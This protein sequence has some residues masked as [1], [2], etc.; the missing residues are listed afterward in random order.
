[1]TVR[2]DPLV[3]LYMVRV[4]ICGMTNLDDALQAASCGADALGFNFYPESPRYVAPEKARAIVSALPPFVTVVGL[5]V[6]AP[7]SEVEE[8]SRDCGVHVLQLH[9]DEGPEFCG[10]FSRPVIRAIQVRDGSFLEDVARYS[11]QGFVLDAYHPAL[12]GGTG[13]VFDWELVRD[14]GRYGKIILAGGLTPE[15][16]AEAIRKGKP[17]A[18]DVASGVER[19]PGVKDPDKVKQFVLN[20][21]RAC[22]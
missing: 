17:Y 22:W 8:I 1:V 2:V 19:S 7:A 10:Q 14:A 13:R 12:Y 4:K 20:A 3:A 21:K 5:F 11:V 16:V 6:N 15:N 18:V 9:G